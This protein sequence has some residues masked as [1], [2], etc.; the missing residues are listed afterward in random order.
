LFKGCSTDAAWD[1]GCRY[2]KDP[3]Q[4][5]LFHPIL[6]GIPGATVCLCGND[7][8]NAKLSQRPKPAH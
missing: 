4:L 5:V 6:K 7:Y 8:C 2:I 3:N 1:G